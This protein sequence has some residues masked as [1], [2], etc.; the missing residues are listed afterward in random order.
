MKGKSPLDSV[1]LGVIRRS[2]RFRVPITRTVKIGLKEGTLVDV[3]N[4]N[5]FV[6]HP[7]ALKV[8][9]EV[10]MTFDYTGRKFIG[11]LKVGSCG[12]VGRVSESGETLYA[13]RLYFTELPEESQRIIEEILTTG[14]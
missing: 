6:T 14:E 4:A 13:S 9:S 2:S 7:G 10:T 11:R 3:S 1:S 12:V 5:A 8:G